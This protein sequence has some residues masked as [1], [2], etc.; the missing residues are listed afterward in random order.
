MPVQELFTTQLLLR[1]PQLDDEA[2]LAA[3]YKRNREHLAPWETLS[4][5]TST[6]G[7][8]IFR[9]RLQTW[10][11]DDEQGTAI[12]LFIFNK[13]TNERKLLGMC[14]FTQ[15]FRGAFQACYLGYKLD[16]EY[17][18]KGLMTEAL[19]RAFRFIFEVE[20]L[21]RIMA[22]YMP[23]NKRSARLL[24]RLGFQIEGYAKNYLM[25][26]DQ[27]E[28]HVLTALSYEHWKQP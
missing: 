11:K 9:D 12:R 6:E 13:E 24:H 25:I 26:N 2:L 17:E 16:H 15:I 27:W 4:E 22:N 1:S 20:G 3:F 10:I 28:D 21:H 14:S 18:G 19:Q 8:G 7:D 23:V 5:P